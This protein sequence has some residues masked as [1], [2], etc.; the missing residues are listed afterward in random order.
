MSIFVKIFNCTYDLTD[1][2]KGLYWKLLVEYILGRCRCKDK[3]TAVIQGR[4]NEGSG[5]GG[6]NNGGEKWPDYGHISLVEA[7]GFADILDV[8]Y[9]SIGLNS[10]KNGLSFSEMRKPVGV[11][12]LGVDR[13]DREI[14]FYFGH[15]K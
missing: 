10:W 8:R 2:L 15:I 14:E 9:E 5:Q 6:R 13:W 11:V 7:K 12:G 4:D 1:I 3:P